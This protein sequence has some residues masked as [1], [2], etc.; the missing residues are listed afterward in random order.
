[1]Q[2]FSV[3]APGKQRASSCHSSSSSPISTPTPAP[4]ILGWPWLQECD[5]ISANRQF[6][7]RGAG[8]A[9]RRPRSPSHSKHKGLSSLSARLSSSGDSLPTGESLWSDKLLG[10]LLAALL[11]L[12][13]SCS[14]I[15]IWGWPGLEPKHLIPGLG[16]GC[17]CCGC[18]PLH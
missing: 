13:W 1:M 8:A 2:P 15:G 9:P 5:G 18:W 7:P 3:W 16:A 17:L 10:P 12:Q 6:V 14:G 11:G 4:S